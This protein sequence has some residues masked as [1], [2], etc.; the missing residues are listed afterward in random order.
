MQ[1]V[2]AARKFFSRVMRRAIFGPPSDSDA[3]AL[4]FNWTPYSLSSVPCPTPCSKKPIRVVHDAFS[5]HSRTHDLLWSFSLPDDHNGSCRIRTRPSR[6]F[7]QPVRR[8]G[9]GLHRVP[10]GVVAKPCYG[11]SA[12]RAPRRPAR[13]IAAWTKP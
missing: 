7:F 5:F 8:D 2:D 4:H 10:P 1:A 9:S 13:S 6:I 12:V 3:H 11:L